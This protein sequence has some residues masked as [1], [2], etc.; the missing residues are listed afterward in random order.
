[1]TSNIIIE[2]DVMVTMRDGVQ[3]ATDIYRPDD[4]NQYPVL[5]NQH[6]YDNDS[7]LVVHELL[8]SPLIAAQK[9]YVVVSQ[10]TRGRA[11]SEGEWRP[12]GSEGKDV[13][14][15]VE[16]AAA[17]PWSNGKVGLYGAC[18]LGL[19]TLQGAVENPPHLKAAL[20]YMTATNFHSGWTYSSGG[21]LELGFQMSWVWKILAGDT[22]SRLDLAPAA[23]QEAGQKLADAA[24]DMNKSASYL[25]LIDFPP[26]QDG[27][28]PYWR[29]WLSHPAYDEFW[30]QVDAVAQAERIKVPVLHFSSWYDTCL[31][32]HMD[33][34]AALLDRGDEAVRHQHRMLIGPTDHSAYYNHRP[35]CAGKRDFGPA[36]ATGPDVVGSIAFQWFDHWLKGEENT[37]N[38]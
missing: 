12:Y 27:A 20:A 7:F 17:Q 21:A 3:L 6:P 30:Q 38:G 1:M 23:L 19:G 18:A 26:Y 22:L 9:G 35:T 2:R 34:D 11:G 13:Y 29:E 28:A 25:P 16:W 4:G 33:L 10:E 5:L 8:F 36:A 37:F 31:K 15:A 14:D 32:G 24:A